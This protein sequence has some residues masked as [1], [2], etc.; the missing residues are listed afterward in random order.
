MTIPTVA[1]ASAPKGIRKKESTQKDGEY[2]TSRR[3]VKD[4]ARMMHL[5]QV[6]HKAAEE[7]TVQALL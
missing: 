5:P 7:E 2:E 3:A 4:F 6:G 1:P